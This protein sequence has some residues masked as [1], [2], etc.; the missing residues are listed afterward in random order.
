MLLG[1]MGADIIKIERPELGDDTRSWGPPFKKAITPEHS[2]ESAYFLAVNRNKR[3]LT[4]NIKE[5]VGKEILYKLIKEAD[6]L[7]ENYLP[8][9]LDELGLSY[10][11]LNEINPKLIYASIT[12]YGPSGPYKN[13]PGYDVM[14]EAE[15]GL[16]HIT[17]EKEGSPVKVGVAITDITT[18]LYAHG[19]IIAALFKRFKTNKGQKLD[20]SLIESQIA[21]L[22]NIASS[23]LIGDINSQRQG[24]EHGSIVPYQS[25]PTK[26]GNIVIGAG[27]DK[28]F[29]ILCENVIKDVQLLNNSKFKNNSERVKN[30][31]ELISILSNYFKSKDTKEWLNI[32]KDFQIPYAPINDIKAALQHPQVINRNMIQSILHPTLGNIKLVGPA[33]KYSDKDV[34]I[35]SPPPTLGQHNNEIL[36]N[37]GYSLKTINE[38]KNN[39]VI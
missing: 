23:Y 6:V 35:R 31:I 11:I 24:T 7:V 39:G 18:G 36:M 9:K 12:G 13:K 5:K 26:D 32:L 10:K 25:F 3:S 16:M 21:C 34:Y 33:V 28:Q 15:G 17:G 37:L 30:R 2:A 29:K 27:N 1:D 19:S 14:V 38:F 4:L 22:A 8:G 20:I